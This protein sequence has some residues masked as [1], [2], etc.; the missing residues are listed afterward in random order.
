MYSTEWKWIKG[1][2]NNEGNEAADK[3]ADKGS[4]HLEGG[5]QTVERAVRQCTRVLIAD[6]KTKV[7]LAS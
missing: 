5:W 2:S 6:F 3:L 1:H 4:G 7:E